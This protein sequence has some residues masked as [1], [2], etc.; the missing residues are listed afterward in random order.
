MSQLYNQFEI[1]SVMVEGGAGILSSFLN[2][3][4]VGDRTSS[5]ESRTLGGDKVVDCI[6]VTIAPKIMGGKWGLPALGGFDVLPD[7]GSKP[8]NSG[9]C[10]DLEEEKSE[11]LR[12]GVITIKDGEFVSLGQ[13]A[14]YLGTI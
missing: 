12:Q 6:C 9:E 2:E 8:E 14:T 1:E 13:D 11:V 5:D 7:F 3:C 10:I 4:V